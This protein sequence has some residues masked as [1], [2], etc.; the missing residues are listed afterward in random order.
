MSPS[1]TAEKLTYFQCMV[2]LQWGTI[3]TGVEKIKWTKRLW[4]TDCNIRFSFGHQQTT[5]FH[6]LNLVTVC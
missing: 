5:N 1:V 3:N 4:N 6:I 2:L